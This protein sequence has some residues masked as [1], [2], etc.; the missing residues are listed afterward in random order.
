MMMAN[1]LRRWAAAAGAPDGTRIAGQAQRACHPR[2][3]RA[4]AWAWLAAWSMA[5][6]GGGSDPVGDNNTA[7]SGLGTPGQAW[8]LR[9]PEG[10]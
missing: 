6:C 4:V 5:G 3:R 9:W 10:E 8:G 7:N 2:R 1:F